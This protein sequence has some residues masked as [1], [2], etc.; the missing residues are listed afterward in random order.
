MIFVSEPEHTLGAVEIDLEVLEEIVADVVNDG[1]DGEDR[2]PL[3]LDRINADADAR[4]IHPISKRGNRRPGP[5][6][7]PSG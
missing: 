6:S 3:D 1:P 4:S 2:L 5:M 7:I